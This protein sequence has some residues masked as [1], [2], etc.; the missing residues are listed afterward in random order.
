MGSV[1]GFQYNNTPYYFQKNIQGDIVSIVNAM[2]V[3][4]VEYTYDAWGKLLTTTG[5][6]VSTIGTYNPFRYRGYYYDSETGLYYVSSRYYDPEIGRW[7]NADGF[8]S[9]GQDITGYNMFAYCGNNPVNRKDPTGQFWITAL[10]VAAVVA[11][12]TVALSGCSAQPS[13]PSNYVQENSTNQNCYSYAF[14]LPHSA[15]P[16]DYSVSGNSDYMFKDKNIYTPEE[17]TEFIQ[18]DMD[19]L[20]KS[21]RVVDS[22]KDKLDNEYIVAMKT[23][24]IVISSIGVADYHFA[25]QLSDGSWADK[26][27][28]KPSRWNVLDGAAIAWDLGNIKNYYNTETVYFAVE[29]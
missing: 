2:G 13:T 15:N 4:V 10:I 9:T 26:P 3:K 20:N 7:I 5:T 6:M 17:I 12:C 16:G 8:V 25:V 14:D 21:V 23:S 11:V 19:A 27:G 22:P 24:T 1:I 28:Q 29:R 18:R